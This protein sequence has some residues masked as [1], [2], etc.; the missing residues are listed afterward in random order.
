MRQ[1]CGNMTFGILEYRIG[2]NFKANKHSFSALGTVVSKKF[3][4]WLISQKVRWNPDYNLY[5]GYSP[6]SSDQ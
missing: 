6:I 4:H 1:I 2:T 3:G 5:C